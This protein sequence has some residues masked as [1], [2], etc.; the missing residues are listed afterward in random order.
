[1]RAPLVLVNGQVTIEDDPET[2]RHPGRL[3]RHGM[4]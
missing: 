2:G 4:Q 1:M 3:L